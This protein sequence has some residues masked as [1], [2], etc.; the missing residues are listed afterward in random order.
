MSRWS[1]TN[2]SARAS[3]QPSMMLAWLRASENTTSPSLRERRHHAGVGE[4]ARAEQQARL[5]ALEVGQ[6]LLQPAVDRHVART[7]GA[8]PRAGAVA[9]GGL[10]G[11]LAHARVVGQPEVVVRAEQQHRPA[12]RAARAGPGARTPPSCAGRA[13]ARGAR[14]GAPRCRSRRRPRIHHAR[15]RA[16][17]RWAARPGPRPRL[18][19]PS[20]RGGT[21]RLG[22]CRSWVAG[23][24]KLASAWLS[25]SS[26]IGVCG[27]LALEPAR[28]V[29]RPRVRA[30]VLLARHVQ[31]Q[32][33]EHRAVP[34]G[35][36]AERG[37]EVAHHHPV[38]ARL[39]GELL[40]LR[41]CPRFSLRPPQ[42]R[43]S[44]SGITSR[45]IATHCTTSIGSISSRSPNLVPGRGLSRLIGHARGL[46]RGELEGHL[47]ALL[48]R[49]AEV[50]DAA[51][52]GLEPGVAHR[53]DRADPALVA[54]RGG[55]L[56]VV[57]L[58]GLHVVVDAL[59][60]R[61]P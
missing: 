50:E 56:V 31:P 60:A 2:V 40:K 38:E 33:L 45:K 8:R 51:H 58:G 34:L 54:D 57:A 24:Q 29:V 27:R 32:P 11:R 30:V 39:D 46:E 21:E 3:R 7:R 26:S 43:K 49:L 9:H 55:H 36:G 10:G 28:A 37:E 42:S 1:Y 48:A 22:R 17:P 6:L 16:A 44:A 15:A 59:D 25:T 61:R 14:R 19:A 53:V 41:R 20:G 47:H 13:R 23:S 12:R 18:G 52:A 35:L 5:G 4:V